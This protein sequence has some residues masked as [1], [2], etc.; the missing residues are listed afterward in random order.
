LTSIPALAL[1]EHPGAWRACDVGKADFTLTLEARHLQALEKQAASVDKQQ[2][3]LAAEIE[4]QH[5]QL[6]GMQ[7]KLELLVN[8][9]NPLG[10][11]PGRFDSI[12]AEE[13]EIALL[14]EKQRRVK[15]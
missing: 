1:I 3:A 6:V 15:P 13:I 5:Q 12:R 2:Q 10:G 11:E 7:Q 14:R 4:E 9:D 8:E